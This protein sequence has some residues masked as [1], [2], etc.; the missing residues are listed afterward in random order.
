MPPRKETRRNRAR[1]T[2]DDPPWARLPDEKLLDLRFCDLDLRI[3]GTWLEE[4]IA[5]LYDELERRG[6]RF[7]PH[8]WLS[9]EWFSPDGVPGIAIPFYLA[10]PRL[11]RLERRRMLEIEGG[12]REWCLK[13]LRHEAGHALDTAYRLRRKRRWQRV[14]GRASQPYPDAYRPKPYSHDFVQHLGWWY[15]QSH[16]L[17]DFAETFAVWLRPGARW[18]RDYDGWSALGKLEYVD[19]VIREVAASRP[20]VRT[21][22]RVDALKKLRRTL[23]EHYETRHARYGVDLSE[24]YDRDLL[25]LFSP[26]GDRAGTSAVAFLRRVRPELRP[27]VSGWTE[28]HPYTVDQFLNDMMTRCRALR[29]RLNRSAE[30]AKL[31]TAV[32]LTVQVMYYVQT[33]GHPIAL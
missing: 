28:Q 1:A 20:Q 22:Q 11:M 32:L 3:E 24:L 5:K 8:C 7:R 10:H 4:M 23:R 9:S 2:H 31:D 30:Q 14:F 33:G 21:R 18:K 26:G 12:T 19:E 29:L 17:E 25:R 6:I 16:P 27:L 13:I 15:A